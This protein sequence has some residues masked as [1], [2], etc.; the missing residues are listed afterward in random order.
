MDIRAMTGG[1]YDGVRAL[2]RQVHALHASARPDI[3]AD[4]DPLSRDYFYTLL[5][6]NA[7]IALVAELS[8]ELIGFCV[9]TL[10]PPSSNP[11]MRARIVAYMEDLC[12][13]VRHRTCGVGTQLFEAAKTLASQRGA[14]SL[15]LMV[16]SFNG[17]AFAFYEHMGMAPRSVIMELP[18]PPG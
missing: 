5:G 4:A 10:R 1:D 17:P 3:Y 12:V 13:D 18:L 2:I 14:S 16:W 15:E 8:G 6:S 11:V 9:V 7:T